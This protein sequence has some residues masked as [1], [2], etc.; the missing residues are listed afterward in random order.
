[1]VEFAALTLFFWWSIHFLLGG[2]VPWM[3]VLR[4]DAKTYGPIGVASHS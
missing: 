3:R 4:S 2:G 1:V